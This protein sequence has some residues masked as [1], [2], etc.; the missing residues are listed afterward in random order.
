MA[1]RTSSSR[2]TKAP[3]ASKAELGEGL[4]IST[5]IIAALGLIVL[6]VLVAVFTGQMGKWTG[7]VESQRTGL[8][9][10]ATDGTNNLA[11]TWSSSPCAAGKSR[12]PTN[13]EDVARHAGL[14]CCGA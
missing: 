7:D 14:Y 8:V 1:R 4:S 9:C 13:N 2:Q 6:V 5:I 3:R 10:Q 12:Y 11:G